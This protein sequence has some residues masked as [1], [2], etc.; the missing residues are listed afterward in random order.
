MLI[1][2]DIYGMNLKQKKTET[3]RK[4]FLGGNRNLTWSKLFF[5]YPPAIS[6]M[7][8]WHARILPTEMKMITKFR[9]I[10]VH[11]KIYVGQARMPSI[12]KQLKAIREHIPLEWF[13]NHSEFERSIKCHFRSLGWL[14]RCLFPPKVVKFYMHPEQDKQKLHAGMVS[15]HIA[16]NTQVIW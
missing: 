11:L 13:E 6:N 4:Y 5:S 15:S 9:N 7:F 3:K 10:C 14:I 1:F 12:N 8:H 2:T 16:K